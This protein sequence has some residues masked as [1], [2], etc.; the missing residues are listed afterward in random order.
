MAVNPLSQDSSAFDVVNP[1]TGTV[2]YRIEEPRP[3][4]LDAVMTAARK[5]ASS[6]R[7]LSVSGRLQIAGR[8]K[9][10]LRNHK[11]AIVQRIVDET[12]KPRI[13]ALMTEIFPSLDLI[14]YYEKNAVKILQDQ[15]QPTPLLLMGKKSK[16][17]YEPLGPVLIISP[18]N[19][20]FNLSMTP[21]LTALI[22]GN[23]VIFK[24]SEYTPLKGLL[25]EIFQAA[26]LPEGFLQV[27]YGAKETGRRLIDL[28]PAKIFFTGSEGA[29]KAIMAQAAQYLIPVELELGGKDPMVVFDD[30]SIPRAVQGALWGAMTNAG[31][32]CTSVERI[33]VQERIQDEFVLQLKAAIESLNTATGTADTSHDKT[34][35]MGCMTADFQIAKVEAQMADAEAKGAKVHCGGKRTDASHAFPPTL[36]TN[37]T[38]DMAIYGEESFGPLVTVM[39]FK[40]EA[41]AIRLAND[42]RYGLCASV[43]TA[44]PERG[45]RVARAI[46]TGGV[47]INNVL[48]TLA[49]AALPFGGTKF[50]GMGRYKGAHGL[51]SFSNVKAILVDK[52]SN[53]K[54]PI[55]YPY[56]EE[57]YGLISALIDASTEGGIKGLLKTMMVGMKLDKFTKM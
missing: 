33:F 44:D 1:R 19:Y 42:T 52:N 36:V 26:G 11:E 39:P 38:P 31:Q 43:W 7:A 12:G 40:D 22:A 24:P 17:Y 9:D 50:S 57:K 53:K 29:G 25:E 18:W 32:T 3:E 55:W 21:I 51:Y 34:L 6:L 49:N 41:E 45:D 48:A 20:P 56:S 46:V 27:V 54:E 2:L 8:V 14:Q 28:Q 13:E 35:D 5:A 10:Y 15:P 16:I 30:A 4:A 37:I 47:S 23:P